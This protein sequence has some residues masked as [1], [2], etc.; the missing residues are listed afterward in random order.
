MIY[1]NYTYHS[2]ADKTKE[3]LGQTHINGRL[4]AAKYFAQRKNLPLKEFLKLYSVSK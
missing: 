3:I 4:L 1:S 2:K